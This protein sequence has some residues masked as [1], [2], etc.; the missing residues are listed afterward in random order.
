ML[1]PKKSKDLGCNQNVKKLVLKNIAMTISK[2]DLYK[3][4]ENFGKVT[5]IFLINPSK[6]EYEQRSNATQYGFVIFVS[7]EDSE[8]VLEQK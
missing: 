1:A 2:Q 5:Q 6:K 4:F 8:K 7:Q 3:Y